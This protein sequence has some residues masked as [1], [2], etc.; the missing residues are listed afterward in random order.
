MLITAS[1]FSGV[2]GYIFG[3]TIGREIK[4]LVE[5]TDEVVA[6]LEAHS[7]GEASN[8]L[9]EFNAYLHRPKALP[10]KPDYYH[11]V[12]AGI[13]AEQHWDLFIENI[14]IENDASSK[15]RILQYWVDMGNRFTTKERNLIE[16]LFVDPTYREKVRQIFLKQR[17][18]KAIAN[19]PKTV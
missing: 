3:H 2:I 7:I 17:K 11:N 4:P 15:I 13:T 9:T 5:T 19:K 10:A 16:Q 18:H 8:L 14:N 1:V 6:Y 12:N